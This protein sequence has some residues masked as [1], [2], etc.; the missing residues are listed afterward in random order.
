MR[1]STIK[2][3]PLAYV[4]QEAELPDR[5]QPLKCPDRLPH[6]FVEYYF[7]SLMIRLREAQ[8][9]HA[10]HFLSVVSQSYRLYL[11]GGESAQVAFRLF[12]SEFENI[13]KA[14]RW[15]A[16]AISGD[17]RAAQP[18]S[19]VADLGVYLLDLRLEQ[20]ERIRWT[21]AALDA[22]RQINDQAA[23][24]LHLS[25]RNCSRV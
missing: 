9:C 7:D 6:E 23:Q 2:D 17:S 1:S 20:R 22:A 25:N 24:A 8:L 11:K 19:D 3:E 10:E 14:Q 15:A 12:D 5:P 4:T 13:Q 16:S 21:E 18:C